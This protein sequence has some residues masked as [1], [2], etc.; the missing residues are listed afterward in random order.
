MLRYSFGAEFEAKLVE[1]AVDAV[2]AA[3]LRTGDIAAGGA[4]IGCRAMGDAIAAEVK[5]L[6]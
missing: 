1:N 5:K 4:S 6:A 3:G 2:L